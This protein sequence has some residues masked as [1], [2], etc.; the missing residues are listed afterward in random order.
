MDKSFIL[1]R[2]FFSFAIPLGLLAG[3]IFLINSSY[4]SGNDAL[5]LA[6]TADL[7]LTIP[8]IYFLL[9]RKTSIPKTTVIPMMLLGLLIGTLFLPKDGQNYL[10]LFKT[11]CLPLIELSVITLIFIKVRSAISK[12]KSQKDASI[13]FFTA[14]KSTCYE[15]LPKQ[16]V[17]PV[18]TEIAVIYYGFVNWK[19]R[20]VKD[21]EFTYHK[22]SGSPALFYTLILII[23]VEAFA[24]HLLVERWS[25][26]AAWA[27]LAL[28]IYSGLQVFGF[29]KS[30]SQ[31]PISVDENSV[32]LRYGILSEVEIPFL[33]I[34]SIELSKKAL[35]KNDFTRKLSPFNDLESHNVVITLKKKSTLTSLYGIKKQFKVLG[36]YVDEPIAFRQ[37]V[38][39][40]IRL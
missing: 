15:I 30:L 24:I 17:W 11:W 31:R 10:S 27:L 26:I 38:N 14:L 22:K 37:K 1:N 5:N 40:A 8:F 33:D 3:L 12:Y 4:L 7:L 16:L 9:I 39:E 28:S 25:V 6:I 13:D 29:A 34:A 35:D 21:N 20:A 2:T 19:P 36:F 18:I 23:V 32:T